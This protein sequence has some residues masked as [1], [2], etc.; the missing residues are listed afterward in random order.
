[1]LFLFSKNSR[2]NLLLFSIVNIV[3]L[4]LG[5]TLHNGWFAAWAVLSVGIFNSVMWPNIFDLAIDGLGKLKE[6]ASSFLVMM[7]LGGAIL[8]VIQGRIADIFN[9]EISFLVPVVGYVYILGYSVFYSKKKF[10]LIK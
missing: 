6:Q 5:A 10:N 8:P 4:V 1:V 7:I 3:S 2:I 9:I